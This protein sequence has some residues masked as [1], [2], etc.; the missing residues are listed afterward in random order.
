MLPGQGLQAEAVRA[1]VGEG[2]PSD[3]CAACCHVVL[4]LT[5]EIGAPE[6]IKRPRIALSGLALY[7]A[8]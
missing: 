6:G 7:V 4:W 3:P 2:L 5:R 8:Q 1:S